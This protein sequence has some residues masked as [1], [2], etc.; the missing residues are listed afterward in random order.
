MRELPAQARGDMLIGTA[1][2]LQRWK[3]V[4]LLLSSLAA[5]RDLA[6]SLSRDR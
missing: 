5:L 1:S 2:N 3:R 4:D 6:D